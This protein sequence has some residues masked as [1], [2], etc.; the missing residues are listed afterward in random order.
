MTET[1]RLY[2]EDVYKKEFTAKVL[3]CREAKKGFHIILDESAF[4]PEGGGQPSDAGYLN[5][6]KVKE[7]HEKMENFFIIQINRWKQEQK[8]RVVSTGQEDLI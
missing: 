5:D 8:Y 2:Y 6:V 4:Y 7:V 1:K 3:E